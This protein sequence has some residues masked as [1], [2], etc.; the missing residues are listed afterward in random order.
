MMGS[1]KRGTW[2][3]GSAR[4][5]KIHPGGLM[6]PEGGNARDPV[7]AFVSSS[8]RSEGLLG[9]RVEGLGV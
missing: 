9:S 8:D 5:L 3:P 2:G 1:F 7:G 4:K 6:R